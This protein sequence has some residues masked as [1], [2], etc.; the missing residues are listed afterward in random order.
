MAVQPEHNYYSTFISAA[1]DCPVTVA[2]EPPS[3]GAKTCSPSSGRVT[4]AVK[5]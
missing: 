3:R 4:T 2:E 1:D 5:S